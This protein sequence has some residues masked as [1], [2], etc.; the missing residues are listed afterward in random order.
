MRFL[1][2]LVSAAALASVASVLAVDAPTPPGWEAR[3]LPP[4]GLH[5]GETPERMERLLGGAKAT[6]EKRTKKGDAEI[7]ETVGLVQTGLKHVNFEFQKGLLTRVTLFYE[8]SEWGGDKYVSFFGE[9]AKRIAEKHGE[10]S[11]QVTEATPTAL[12]GEE[13]GMLKRR[14]AA[15]SRDDTGLRLVYLQ[16]KD[17]PPSWSLRVEYTG[18]ASAEAPAVKAPVTR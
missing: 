8:N 18:T 13:D 15:W 2:M 16:S 10:P 3:V 5:W 6:I 12:K 4:F 17:A 7:W 1:A 9:V 11:R 14:E